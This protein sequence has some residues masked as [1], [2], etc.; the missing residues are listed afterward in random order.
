MQVTR[1]DSYLIVGL[2][3]RPWNNSWKE[4]S[5]GGVIIK[6]KFSTGGCGVVDKGQCPGK[7]GGD[8]EKTQPFGSA[9][10]RS[11][12]PPHPRAPQAPPGPSPPAS[13]TRATGTA[14]LPAPF[15]SLL[16]PL[17]R[18]VS[19]PP[20]PYGFSPTPPPLLPTPCCLRDSL[21]SMLR[22]RGTVSLLRREGAPQRGLTHPGC[23]R[24]SA[25]PARCVEGRRR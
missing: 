18:V 2:F 10:S 13:A 7:R 11:R 8:R 4:A 19:L 9:G 3:F 22:S 17:L 23:L 24:G 21:R 6:E 15:P 1:H 5:G 20:A 25:G 14:Q 16:A 12:R